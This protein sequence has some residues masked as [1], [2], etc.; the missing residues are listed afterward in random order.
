MLYFFI[1]LFI[2][3]Y[4]DFNETV[5]ATVSVMLNGGMV[6]INELVTT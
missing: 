1:Y 4:T 5:R 2:Y 6:V 3:L